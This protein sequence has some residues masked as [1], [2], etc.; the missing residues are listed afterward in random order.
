MKTRYIIKYKHLIWSTLSL[1]LIACSNHTA[2]HVFEWKKPQWG[3]LPIQY[4]A[5]AFTQPKPKFSIIDIHK[6]IDSYYKSDNIILMDA[7]YIMEKDPYWELTFITKE[8]NLRVVKVTSDENSE[9]LR[10]V[11]TIDVT[12][13]NLPIFAFPWNFI[14]KQEAKLKNSVYKVAWCSNAKQWCVGKCK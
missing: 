10:D 1:N 13:E 3:V 11:Q 12:Q 5:H 2:I 14:K 6:T 9:L 8:Y 7:E 4:P